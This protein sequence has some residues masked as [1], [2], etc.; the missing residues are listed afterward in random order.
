MK[1]KDNNNLL[2][3]SV[4]EQKIIMNDERFIGI[5]EK[6]SHSVSNIMNLV[7][8]ALLFITGVVIKDF[9]CLLIISSII[10]IKLILTL[11]YSYYYNK[12]L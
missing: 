5:N 1:S 8:I 11:I 4:K 2:S 9:T 10:I 3:K 6:T 12:K 7:L